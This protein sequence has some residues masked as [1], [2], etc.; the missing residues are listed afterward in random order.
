MRT[1]SARPIQK[2]EKR[3]AEMNENKSVLIVKER[4]RKIGVD[5]RSNC[6][7]MKDYFARIS[8]GSSIFL[9][10]ERQQQ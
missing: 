8:Q 5:E 2:R 6:T 7:A 4:K 10:I 9:L 3:I 1:R